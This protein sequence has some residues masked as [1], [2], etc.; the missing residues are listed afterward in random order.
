MQMCWN[1]IVQYNFTKIISVTI[2]VSMKNVSVLR[3]HT[4]INC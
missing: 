1:I 3:L 2:T 4:I